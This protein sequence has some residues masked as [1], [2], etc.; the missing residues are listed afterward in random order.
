M[1]PIL[2]RAAI[3]TTIFIS[4]SAAQEVAA[5]S[6]EAEAAPQI[7]EIVVRAR[8]RAELL[9]DTPVSVTALGQTQLRQIGATRLDDI[10][11]RVPNLVFATPDDGAAVDIRIR[12]IGTPQTVSIA[13]DPGVGV[14]VDGV[15]LPRTIGTL[16]DVIDV[17]Q[18]EV[19]RGP[20]GT[21]FGKNT[22]GGAINITT[23]KPGPDLEGMAMVR[24]GNFDTVQSRAM[25]NV[26]IPWGALEDRVFT[27]FAVSQDYNEGYTRNTNLGQRQ[28]DRN[29]LSFLGSV[30]LLPRDDITVDL[31]GTWSRSH[32]RGR[33]GECVVVDERGPPFGSDDFYDACRSTRPF[34]NNADVSQLVDVES[35]GAWGTLAWDLG[36]LRI[37]DDTEL[38]TIAS[39]RE[40]NPRIR[41]DVD[42]TRVPNLR[43]S[44]AG[45]APDQG[46][47]GEQRQISIEEQVNTTTWDGRLQIVTGA[48]GFWEQAD[49]SVVL[50]ADTV[51]AFIDNKRTIHN[52]TWALYGQATAELTDWASLTAGLR[53]TQDK[54]GLSLTTQTTPGPVAEPMN[55]SKVFSAWT[56]MASLALFAPDSWIEDTPVDHLMGYFTYSRGFRGGGF[57]GIA[58]STDPT[59]FE[60]EFLDSFEIGF[61]SIGFDQRATLNL[62]AFLGKYDDIQVTGVRDLGDLNGDGIPDFDQTTLNAAEATTYGAEIELTALPY[63][64]FQLDGS[65]GLLET[66]YDRFGNAVSDLDSSRIDRSGQSFD[67]APEIQAHV[68]LQYAYFLATGGPAWLEGILTPRIDWS[69]QSEVHL[70]GPEVAATV[71]RGYNRIDARLSY[72]FNEE[73]TQVALWGRNLTDEH[74]FDNATP[75]VSSLGTTSRFYAAPRTYGCEVSHRFH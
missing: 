73:R 23:V 45:G 72:T 3:L 71:Q 58:L 10:Q 5:Q 34:E 70:R 48:F 31:S 24:A 25:L 57:N 51:G 37:F 49:E 65:L 12:G 4:T 6:R 59:E 11:G 44:S 47:P 42:M 21:L 40:Q 46:T 43:R 9:E 22:V 29:S 38:K 74:Y 8:K 18:I 32:T 17:E 7:E 50:A 54:K 14:Y 28:S 67:N 33:G 36:E 52:W 62:S 16:V 19:L 35:Y 75:T 60:P 30:R 56:P 63:E 41:V 69:Y 55:E 1:T 53:Y 64:G 2:R 68:G 15:F 13:F 39:W 26:P 66:E 27:R 20:Q 61:K